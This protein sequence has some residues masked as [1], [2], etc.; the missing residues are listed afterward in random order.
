MSSSISVGLTMTRISRPAW[1][2]YTRSTPFFVER[3]LLQRLEPLDVVLETLPSRAGARGGDRVGGD[4]QHGLDGLGLHLVVVR[5]DRVDDVLRLAVALRLLRGD[6]RVR[7][8]DLVR[9]RLAEV[10]Q[11]SRPLRRLHARAELRGHDPG[12]MGAL[13]RVLE[14][15]L[16][17]ARPVAKPAE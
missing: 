6:G 13:E 9:H 8:L 4:D 14:D 17:V 5:L 2:A 11:K 10:V 3:D 16:P 15:V 1:S 7:A 12:E